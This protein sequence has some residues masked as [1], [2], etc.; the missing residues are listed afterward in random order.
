MVAIIVIG[1]CVIIALI[2]YIRV[3]KVPK[4]GSLALVTGGVKTGKSTLS[5]HLA[6]RTY[7]K[8]RLKWKVQKILRKVFKFMPAMEEPLLYSNV[9]LA[10]IKYVPLTIDLLLRQERFR[11]RSVVYIQEA[12]LVEDSMLFKNMEI[13]ERL[14]YFNKLIGHET[15]GGTIIYDT[16]AIQ[17]CH[18][19]I[20]RSISSY[21]W[22][23]HNTKIP[24]FVLVYVRE[25]FYSEDGAGVNVFNEDVEK[26]LLITIIPKA[27]WKRFDAYCYSA[28]TDH[29]EVNDHTVYLPKIRFTTPLHARKTRK[30]KLR[31]KTILSL[32]KALEEEKYDQKNLPLRK[33]SRMAAPGT[34]SDLPVPDNLGEQRNHGAGDVRGNDEQ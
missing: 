22:I 3:R 17:D 32:R 28:L 20:K 33:G 25:M 29:L 7:K 8:N 9:P 34:S 1:I 14:L 23:H 2:A 19:A 6:I 4:V 5:V 13:N 31:T 27:I 24:F 12:S 21:L 11:Y 18:Y 15:R 30:H 16:Q 26:T 10:G